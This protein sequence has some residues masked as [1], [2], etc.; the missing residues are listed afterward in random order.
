MTKI[1]NIIGG[2]GNQMFQ[3][4]L[5]LTLQKR[6]GEKIY[7]DT[8][9]FKTY[10]LHN[11]L[12][13]ERIFS[14]Q[15]N[16]ALPK[17]ISRLAYYSSNYKLNRA[18]KKFL[19]RKKTMCMEYPLNRFDKGLLF[20]SGDM[21]YEGY[22]Q[23][24]SY[25]EEYRNEIIQVFQFN[26]ELMCAEAKKIES[27]ILQ[28]Q[29]P[30]S[31]HVRRGD[32]LSDKEFGGICTPQYYKNAIDEI[33]KRCQNPYFYIF[34]ND[35]EWCRKHL[36]DF[37]QGHKFVDCNKGEDSWCDMYLMSLCK[38]MIIAN[39]S[40]SWWA[41]YLNLRKDKIV[42]APPIWTH[43]KKKYQRQLPNWILVNNT[44]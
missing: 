24:Y 12:E 15:L 39:S 38:N 1:V 18:M 28:K 30:I 14:I 41:A 43:N 40:F 23:H 36:S 44:E 34:S 8:S 17:D 11:G 35:I 19:P 31:I 29:E 33:Y 4:A 26:K 3:Y 32:Y 22:W 2:L 10:K 9:S 37:M 27:S 20:K 25:F 16:V 21:Y 7:A 13:L 42:F 5:L 6:F